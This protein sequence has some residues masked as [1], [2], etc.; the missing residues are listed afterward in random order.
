MQV[1]VDVLRWLPV[2]LGSSALTLGT[3]GLLLALLPSLQKR[4]ESILKGSALYLLTGVLFVSPVFDSALQLI[5]PSP[6][7]TLT[8][9]SD[10]SGADVY[11]GDKFLGAT[12]LE[13]NLPQGTLFTYRIRARDDVPDKSLYQPFED[14]VVLEKDASIDVWLDRK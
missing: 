14:S 7:V 9:T 11:S 8:L 12:P 1:I 10:P 5:D 3:A 13:L 4:Q 6:T 2:V